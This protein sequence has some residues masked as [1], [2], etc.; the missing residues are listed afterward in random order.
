MLVLGWV[1]LWNP[2]DRLLFAWW[3]AL[4]KRRL[5]ERLAGATLELRV[6]PFRLPD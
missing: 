2:Y 5:V 4:K 1:A 6:L 3:P